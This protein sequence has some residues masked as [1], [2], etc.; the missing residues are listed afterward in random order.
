MLSLLTHLISTLGLV[1]DG[2]PPEPD[3][4]RR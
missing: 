4:R 2:R 1:A 3:P